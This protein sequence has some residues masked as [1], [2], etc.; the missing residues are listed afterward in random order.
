MTVIYSRHTLII[1]N[2]S[3]PTID[4][5]Q[6]SVVPAGTTYTFQNGIPAGLSAMIN[7]V[8]CLNASGEEVGC[9][10][11]VNG[12]VSFTAYPAEDATL[13]FKVTAY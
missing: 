5:G 13:Q 4:A 9:D 12:V 1:A 2:D 10:I 6:I 11:V 8:S 7:K 3:Y